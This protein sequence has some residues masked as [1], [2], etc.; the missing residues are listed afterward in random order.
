MLTAGASAVTLRSIFLKPFLSTTKRSSDDNQ[1]TDEAPRRSCN[2]ILAAMDLNSEIVSDITDALTQ[3]RTGAG[4]IKD[5]V[6]SFKEVRSL[7]SSG[8]GIPSGGEALITDLYGKLIDAQESNALL[9]E[10]MVS[11]R[12]KVRQIEDFEAKRAQ[13]VLR[14]ASPGSFVLFKDAC[15]ET[16][17]PAHCACVTCAEHGKISILQSDKHETFCPDCGTR[18]LF[19]LSGA[20][21]R[22]TAV[23]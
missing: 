12:E 3:A 21:E 17:E 5:I 8:K 14:E 15:P 18:L 4:S 11:L 19:R 9:H 2:G 6:S 16:G 20:L 23:G 10:M 1:D 7:F 22:L 13:Y